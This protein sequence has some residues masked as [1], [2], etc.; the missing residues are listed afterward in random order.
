MSWLSGAVG[1][2]L[3]SLN[4]DSPRLTRSMAGIPSN[5]STSLI[6]FSVGGVSR[7]LTCVGRAPCSSSRVNAIRD[8][9]QRGLCQIVRVVMSY[10]G[11]FRSFFDTKQKR[12]EEKEM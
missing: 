4:V 2:K 8:L 10:P 7:Y 11:W 12:I 5:L 1:D 3:S 6:S 9:E